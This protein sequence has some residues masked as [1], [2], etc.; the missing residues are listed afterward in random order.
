MN[1][2]PSD[3]QRRQSCCRPQTNGERSPV[4]GLLNILKPPGMTSHDV[5]AQVRRLTGTKVGH[6]GTLDPLAAGV[7]V[8]TVGAGTRLTNFIVTDDKAYRAEFVLGVETDTLDLEGKVVAQEAA[9]HIT[10]SQV[11]EAMAQMT[12]E[13]EMVPPMFSAARHEGRKLYELARQGKDVP[14]RARRVTVARLELLGFTPG[15]SPVCAC[16]IECSK[17][18][19]VRSIA[20]M[21]GQRLGCGAHLGFLLRTAQG[22]HTVAASLT[23]EEFTAF[24]REGTAQEAMIPL[25]DAL[26]HLQIVAVDAAQAADLCHGRT[27]PVDTQMTEAALVMVACGD[28]A[29]CLA[30][31]TGGQAEALLRPK[32]V[33]TR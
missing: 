27:T 28:R 21:L 23:M 9:D 1:H 5:V 7:L 17:G 18:T 24:A 6:T 20:Q 15:Q 22:R 11:A 30:E 14:R 13:L 19:Y 10:A 3:G 4:H 8:L 12:G 26:P 33:F 31:L 2:R 32:T 16:D 25:L 29:V